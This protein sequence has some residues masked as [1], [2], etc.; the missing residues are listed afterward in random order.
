[1]VDLKKR[2]EEL[3]KNKAIEES[4]GP[5]T[6]QARQ[7]HLEQLMA[8]IVIVLFIGFAGMFV[9]VG[10]MMIDSLFDKRD[11]TYGL[12]EKI[13]VQN[14]KIEDLKKAIEHSQKNTK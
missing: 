6:W 11:S 2:L 7:K 3:E 5:P 4:Q 12:Q 9:A 13:D 10:Q 1:M 14:N 8:A